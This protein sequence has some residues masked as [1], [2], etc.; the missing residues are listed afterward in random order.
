MSFKNTLYSYI[1]ISLSTIEHYLID[2]DDAWNWE[3]NCSNFTEKHQTLS[4]S[5]N[6]KEPW[7][8]HGKYNQYQLEN[9]EILATNQENN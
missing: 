5:Q 7:A 2:F 1:E 6:S 4:N 9:S 8:I 3:A